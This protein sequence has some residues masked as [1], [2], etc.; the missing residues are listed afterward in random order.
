[1][2][3]L[4]TVTYVCLASPARLPVTRY[5]QCPRR[6]LRRPSFSLASRVSPALFILT[7]ARWPRPHVH[8]V[9]VLASASAC[10]AVGCTWYACTGAFKVLGGAGAAHPKHSVCWVRLLLPARVPYEGRHGGPF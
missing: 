3:R 8:R 1:M 2:W 10:Q 5:C 7:A 6:H 9:L 4:E